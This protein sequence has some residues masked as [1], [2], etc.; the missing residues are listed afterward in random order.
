MCFLPSRPVYLATQT[1][2]PEGLRRLIGDSRLMPARPCDDRG[3]SYVGR[4][5]P[6]RSPEL[7]AG[8]I[9]SPD[10]V[11]DGSI[12]DGETVGEGALGEEA[13][14]RFPLHAP[15]VQSQQRLHRLHPEAFQTTEGQTPPGPP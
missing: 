15:Y 9:A 8:Q 14:V 7:V 2:W 10:P 1:I 12:G 13:G 3:T 6:P 5:D 11:A 4:V